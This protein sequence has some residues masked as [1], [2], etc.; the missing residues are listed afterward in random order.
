M[1]GQYSTAFHQPAAAAVQATY[2]YKSGNALM[3]GHE[4]NL[5]TQHIELGDY[6]HVVKVD[7]R[8]QPNK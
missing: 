8:Q 2:G 7:W 6:E 3:V 4:K 5:Y 1:S